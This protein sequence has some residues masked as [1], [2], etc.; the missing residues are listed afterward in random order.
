M[1]LYGVKSLTLN[2]IRFNKNIVLLAVINTYTL[3]H[4]D[5]AFVFFFESRHQIV[6]PCLRKEKLIIEDYKKKRM[7][8]VL[9]RM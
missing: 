4:S 1:D 3:P 6:H 7:K 2:I 9:I 5:E 8:N